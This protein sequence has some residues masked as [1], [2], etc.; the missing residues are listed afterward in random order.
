[1]TQDQNARNY[2][3]RSDADQKLAAATRAIGNDATAVLRIFSGGFG[4]VRSVSRCF[5]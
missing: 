4:R 5:S 2:H 1:M 3:E